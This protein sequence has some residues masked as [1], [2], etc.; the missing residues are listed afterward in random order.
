MLRRDRR[1]RTAWKT[2][3]QEVRHAEW[4]YR[5][6]HGRIQGS[7]PGLAA[8]AKAAPPAHPEQVTI[9]SNGDFLDLRMAQW[10]L[11]ALVDVSPD[12]G[13]DRAAKRK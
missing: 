11:T 12:L 5:E 9:G 2:V 4:A 1:R 7:T 6:Q 13:F 3:R 8:S 10:F